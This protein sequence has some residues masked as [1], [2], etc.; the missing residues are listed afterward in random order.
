MPN[1][2]IPLSQ[3]IFRSIY[4]D[5]EIFIMRTLKQ[6][7]AIT[8][9]IKENIETIDADFTKTVRNVKKVEIEKV[10]PNIIKMNR[11][12]QRRY[13]MERLEKKK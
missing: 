10:D 9:E 12:I 4:P 7:P 6:T 2:Y 5:Q 8:S 11:L 1:R 3:T 13:I